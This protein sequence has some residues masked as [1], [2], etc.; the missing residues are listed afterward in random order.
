MTPRA[1]DNGLPA[2]PPRPRATTTGLDRG[3]WSGRRAT[4]ALEQVRAHGQRNHLPCFICGDPINYSLRSPN[5]LSCSVQHIKNKRD[6]PELMWDPTNWAPA[7][8]DC[9]RGDG[10]K[11]TTAQ[12]IGLT[13]L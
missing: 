10:T 9:N 13:S 5:G 11:G 8:L 7:H 6:Y 1:R 3:T 4:E 2:R 12:S